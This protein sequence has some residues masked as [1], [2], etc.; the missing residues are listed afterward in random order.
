M[1]ADNVEIVR[2]AY[3]RERQAARMRMYSDP[4]EALR[5]AGLS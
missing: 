5:A 1:S 4:D 3:D 2:R